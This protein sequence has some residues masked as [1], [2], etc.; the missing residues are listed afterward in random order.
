MKKLN[1]GCGRQ[2]K[3][4]WINVDIQ[5]GK[6]VD[7]SFDFNKF[8][9]PFKTNTFDYVLI[10]NVLEH[11]DNIHKVMNELWRIC[12]KGAIIEIFVPYWNHS[13]AYNDA[14][15]KH[16]FNTRAFE[17]LCDYEE[18]YKLKPTGKLELIKVK[19]IAGNIKERIPRPILN[20]LDKF[21]H[22]I[23]IEI[24][25]KIKVKNK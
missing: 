16:Y 21:L 24:N 8:P 17:I 6:G 12:K 11:L 18:T 14:T 20:F 4:G 22:G 9:Y 25:T 13:V 23:F 5:K 19:R 10:D 15:H 1:L 7:K 3:E 2:I